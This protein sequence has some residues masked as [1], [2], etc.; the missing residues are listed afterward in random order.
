MTAHRTI[1]DIKE[2]VAKVFHVTVADLDSHVRTK[3][4]IIARHIAMW[5]CRNN[6]S[7][8][9]PEIGRAFGNRDHTTVISAVQKIDKDLSQGMDQLIAVCI[10]RLNQ[11]EESC[12]V[13]FRVE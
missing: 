4:L 2:A 9:Y 12:T 6:T 10:E 5:L 3:Q 11:D 13:K 1:S 8:S 7:A